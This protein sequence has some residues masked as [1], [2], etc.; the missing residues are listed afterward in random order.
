MTWASIRRSTA[1]LPADEAEAAALIGS[2]AD[3]VVGGPKKYLLVHFSAMRA[4]YRAAS[5]RQL[6]VVLWGLTRTT[7][8]SVPRQ[9]LGSYVNFRLGNYA[10]VHKRT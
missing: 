2:G 1:V 8:P 10:S 4:F 9:Q 5:Q 7:S 3:K 6:L